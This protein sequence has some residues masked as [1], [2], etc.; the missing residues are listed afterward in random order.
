MG[1]Y[2]PFAVEGKQ[3]EVRIEMQSGHVI[4]IVTHGFAMMEG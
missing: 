4:T 2:G 1:A 3:Q